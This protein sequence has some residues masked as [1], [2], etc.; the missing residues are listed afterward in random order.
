VEPS[1][2]LGIF[3]WRSQVLLVIAP[4]YFGGFDDR[5]LLKKQR[6]GLPLA[7]LKIT[8]SSETVVATMQLHWLFCRVCAVLMS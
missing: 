2:G 3:D 7:L 1:F 5:F 8:A 6:R 4:S